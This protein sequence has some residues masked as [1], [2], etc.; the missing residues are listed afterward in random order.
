MKVLS[1]NEISIVISS[2]YLALG[3]NGK[4]SPL[5]LLWDGPWHSLGVSLWLASQMKWDPLGI[6]SLLIVTQKFRNPHWRATF[7]TIQMPYTGSISTL[8]L[9]LHLSLKNGPPKM[10]SLDCPSN[11]LGCFNNQTTAQRTKGCHTKGFQENGKQASKQWWAQLPKM[12]TPSIFPFQQLRSPD[13]KPNLGKR[14]TVDSWVAAWLR[15]KDT[16]SPA[17][18]PFQRAQLRCS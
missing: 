12:K 4:R 14:P 1:Q 2:L 10:T 13:E 17:A 8:K 16:V 15:V 18:V 11:I 5:G 3:L 6:M 9:M 7:K